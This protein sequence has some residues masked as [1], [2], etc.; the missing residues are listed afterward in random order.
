MHILTWPKIDKQKLFLSFV[1]SCTEKKEKCFQER[2][3]SQV[4]LRKMEGGGSKLGALNSKLLF[5]NLTHSPIRFSLSLI[6]FPMRHPF[7]PHVAL[8][9][10]LLYRPNALFWD[11]ACFHLSPASLCNVSHVFKD[12][13]STIKPAVPPS[14]LYSEVQGPWRATTSPSPDTGSLHASLV[15]R[16]LWSYWGFFNLFSV[17]G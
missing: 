15:E 13:H 5:C 8:V 9:S 11:H 12:V 10:I 2:E 17:Y 1:C 14:F 4:N 16:P 7:P 6:L 3:C